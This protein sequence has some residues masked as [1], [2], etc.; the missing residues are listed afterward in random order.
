MVTSA[1][2]LDTTSGLR[3]TKRLRPIIPDDI[4]RS[5]LSVYTEYLIISSDTSN[6]EALDSVVT[7]M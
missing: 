6:P 4:V 3:F 1:S 5:R 7:T 2:A